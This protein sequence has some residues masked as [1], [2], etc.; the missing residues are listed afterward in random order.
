MKKIAFI[1]L[2]ITGNLVFA[3]S[4]DTF[5]NSGTNP[6]SDFLG[7]T[8]GQ[9]L[10]IKTNGKERLRF[11]PNGKA[12]FTTDIDDDSFVV[13]NF[14]QNISSQ[15]D[16]VN[17]GL[18]Y[19]QP[20]DVG[21]LNLTAPQSPTDWSRPIF[22]VRSTGKVMMGISWDN[23]LMPTCADCSD[24]RLFVK[25]GIRTE[26]VKVDIAVSNGWADYVFKDDYQ[27][28]S[29]K[30]VENFI[31]DNGHLPEVPSEK[32]AIENGI[33]LKAMNILL[34]KK[35]EELTLYIIQQSQ[36]IDAIKEKLLKY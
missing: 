22:S 25:D 33:E 19:Y 12:R 14:A 32:E 9:D 5:G 29:L 20:N 28:R 15:K 23:N 16:V 34:L 17:I 21:L 13:V 24:Y 30:E 36:E 7:T 1:A 31:K 2:M 27:L 26:K 3:Q 6:D 8:D 10:I 4:W 11:H 18:R 35:I